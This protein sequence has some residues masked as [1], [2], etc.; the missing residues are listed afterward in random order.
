MNSPDMSIKP[1][2]ENTVK[3]YLDYKH[4]LDSARATVKKP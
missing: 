3:L 2:G 1:G 4:Y